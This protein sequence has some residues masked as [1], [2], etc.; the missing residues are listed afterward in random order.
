MPLNPNKFEGMNI[1]SFSG[2]KDSTAMLHLMLDAGDPIAAIVHF[3]TGW[4]FPQMAEH[5]AA[6]EAQ[7]GHGI[8]RLSA[9]PSFDWRL[10]EQPIEPRTAKGKAR[11]GC[12][13]PSAMRRWCTR[14]KVNAIDRYVR[15]HY[16]NAVQCVGF[17]SDEVRRTETKAQKRRQAAKRVRYPLIESGIT[18]A[19]ALQHCLELGYSWGG[20]Y[21]SFDR[22]S[23]FCCPLQRLGNLRKLRHG[24]PDLWARMMKIEK[25]IRHAEGR[26]FGDE[27]TVSDFEG[28][29]AL[30]DAQLPLFRS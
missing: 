24:F 2:G 14:E 10:T 15:A 5:L 4:E 22:V 3:D 25:R 27:A 28:R 23:C 6:V 9:M 19:V 30:E 26:R 20:L 12:G 29:F 8:V 16:P 13:W 18:E 21:D 11:I 7:T 1:V 17:A